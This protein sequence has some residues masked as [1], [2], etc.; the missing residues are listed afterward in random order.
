MSTPK[1]DD[2]AILLR[3]FLAP[4]T[5]GKS[6]T[7]DLWESIPKFRLAKDRQANQLLWSSPFFFSGDKW[8]AEIRAAV[9]PGPT[10]KGLAIFPGPREQLV[11][12]VLVE[13]A[14]QHRRD[15]R[16]HPTEIE[17]GSDG[18]RLVCLTTTIRE[19]RA[20]LESYG[21]GMSHADVCQ[22]LDVLAAA[23]F[24]LERRDRDNHGQ[25]QARQVGG[26]FTASP[27]PYISYTRFRPSPSD[28]A[29]AKYRIVLN[30]VVSHS[31]VMTQYWPVD[32]QMVL[33]LESPLARWI[34]S[35]LSH[36]YRQAPGAFSLSKTPPY[37]L[38]LTAVI[39]ESGI[40]VGERMR[41]TIARVRSA[42]QS[43]VDAGILTQWQEDLSHEDTSGRPR[44]VDAVW[45]LTTSRTW[46]EQI[47]EGNREM[48]LR[49]TLSPEQLQLRMATP[50]TPPPPPP[51]T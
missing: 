13:I 45:H 4:A 21:H 43:L 37:T 2:N 12:S 50:P 16:P 38:S 28:L 30:R 6:Y 25:P 1:P 20:V 17:V 10:K 46:G 18:E 24:R 23:T 36:Q 7:L 11:F 3:F 49:R 51:T 19:I 27:I 22:A 34:A 47:V 41:D 33:S 8:H 32:H 44:I 48:Q 35:R 26:D 31:I 14:A 15:G 39:L 29:H 40:T 5:S 42:L 9:V